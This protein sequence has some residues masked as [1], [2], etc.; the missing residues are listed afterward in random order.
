MFGIAGSNRIDELAELR[1]IQESTV[2]DIDLL[3]EKDWVLLSGT[4][5]GYDFVHFSG[6]DVS[7]FSEIHPEYFLF[8][9]PPLDPPFFAGVQ[10][11]EKD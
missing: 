10:V 5:D 3:E 9:Y 8:N 4:N 6:E 11:V 7:T 1:V 2:I